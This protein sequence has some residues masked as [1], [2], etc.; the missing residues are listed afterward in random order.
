MTFSCPGGSFFFLAV[1]GLCC[2]V[3][4]SLAVACKKYSTRGAWTS[5]SEGP[6]CRRARA[7]EH[8]GFSVCRVW[9]QQLLFP[10]PGAQARSLWPTGLAALSMRGLP[11][12]EIKPVPPALAGGFSTS[13][14]PEKCPWAVLT[15]GGEPSWTP[16]DLMMPVEGGTAGA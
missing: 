5:P 16:R 1:R 3:D 11:R 6:S 7:L 2:W 12:P 10:G 8:V 9:V 4:F 13:E 14:P 15:A